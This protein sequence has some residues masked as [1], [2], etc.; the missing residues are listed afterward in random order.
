MVRH[1]K[2][3]ILLM[4]LLVVLLRPCEADDSLHFEPT[5][6][7]LIPHNTTAERSVQKEIENETIAIQSK[8]WASPYVEELS[9]YLIGEIPE[10]VRI[11]Y[12]KQLTFLKNRQDFYWK[13]TYLSE[14]YLQYKLIEEL[15]H[16]LIY[17]VAETSNGSRESLAAIAKA[18]DVRYVLNYSH[19]HSYFYEGEKESEVT[20]QLYDW[21]INEIIIDKSYTG[22]PKNPGFD[23]AC[24]NGTIECTISNALSKVLF[25]VSMDVYKRNSSIQKKQKLEKRRIE[26]LKELY[27]EIEKADDILIKIFGSDSTISTEGYYQGFYN[28]SKTK[29]ITF[30]LRKQLGET[31]LGIEL[32]PLIGYSICGIYQKGEWYIQEN[33]KA[34]LESKT[35]DSAK[36]EYF[37]NLQYWG[38]FREETTDIDPP[39]WETNFFAKVEDV[40][41]H[42]NYEKYYESIYKRAER[43]NLG[44][45]GMYKIVADVIKKGKGEERQVF[46]TDLSENL[47]LPFYETMRN[48]DN[49]SCREYFLLREKPTLIY[50][51]SRALV[52]NPI[53][54]TGNSGRTHLRYFVIFPQNGSIFEWIYFT[55]LELESENTYFSSELIEQLQELTD[56]NFGFKTLEDTTFWNTYVSGEDSSGY[57]HLKTMDEL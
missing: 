39:F 14:R 2:Q 28:D 27:F 49:I 4:I 43:E 46:E 3:F 21:Q 48:N 9:S 57:K 1:T 35:I 41:L 8:D 47:L 6:V 54:I 10:N 50:P 34:Y 26:K 38:F 36:L 51:E 7:I 19:I 45:V 37:N 5:M 15:P 13:A 55:P 31:L 42:P 12:N 29:F 17:A 40:T 11:M 56:W 23:F 52:L 30:F 16:L 44:Y 33:T 25:D 20:F 24:E 22:G 32:P 53:S 18:H